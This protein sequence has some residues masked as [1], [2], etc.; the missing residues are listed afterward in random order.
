[1][2]ALWELKSRLLAAEGRL[3]FEVEEG[4]ER[5]DE[6]LGEGFRVEAAGWKG[7]EGP[8]IAASAGKLTPDQLV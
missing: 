3:S 4:G 2:V 7:L 5:L 8:A 1:M 6:L